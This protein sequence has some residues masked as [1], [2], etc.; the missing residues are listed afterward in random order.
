MT[1][2]KLKGNKGEKKIR[3]EKLEGNKSPRLMFMQSSGGLIDAE[4]FSGDSTKTTPYERAT[5]NNSLFFLIKFN[6]F[7][8]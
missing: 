3:R 1:N 5:N 2:E 4:A 7:I 6:V 8:K